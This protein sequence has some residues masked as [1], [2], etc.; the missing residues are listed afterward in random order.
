MVVVVDVDSSAALLLVVVVVAVPVVKAAL[1]FCNIG[2]DGA[3]R[4]QTKWYSHSV[5]AP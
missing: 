5:Q 2:A 3:S 4:C 1:L